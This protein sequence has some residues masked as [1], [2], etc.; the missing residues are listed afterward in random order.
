MIDAHCHLQSMTFPRHETGELI[1]RLIADGFTKWVVNGTSEA[2]WEGVADLAD[3][4]PNHVIPSFGLHPWFVADRSTNWEATLLGWLDRY[5]NAA[6]GEIGLDRWKEGHDIEVQLPLFEAQWKAAVARDRPITVHCL[7]AWGMLEE[8]VRRLPRARFLLHSFSG[9][10]EMSRV[11]LDLGAFFSVSGYFL[12]P[13][14]QSK[15]DVFFSIPRNRILFETDAPDMSPPA[16]LD[17]HSECGFNHPE[18][19]RVV[20]EKMAEQLPMTPG[21]LENLI[22]QNFANWYRPTHGEPGH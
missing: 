2:D 7:R 20:Y 15:L 16:S 11:F 18:N 5:P 21:S 1:E 6:V 17:L 10:T 3:R 12:D 9:S 8:S 14:K 4:F 13:E 19:L 22:A